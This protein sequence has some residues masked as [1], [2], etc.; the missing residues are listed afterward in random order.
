MRLFT[1]YKFIHKTRRSEASV[2]SIKNRF[3]TFINSPFPGPTA[4]LYARIVR[5]LV[6]VF[7]KPFNG[8]G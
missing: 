8:C 5:I 6:Y 7:P 1:C 3:A 4:G 2:F